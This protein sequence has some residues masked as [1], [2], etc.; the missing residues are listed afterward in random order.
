MNSN[1]YKKNSPRIIHIKN[2]ESPNRLKIGGTMI[3]GP[4]FDIKKYL[5][6]INSGQNDIKK[7]NNNLQILDNFYKRTKNDNRKYELSTIGNDNLSSYRRNQLR[8]KSPSVDRSTTISHN[9]NSITI[10]KNKNSINTINTINDDDNFKLRKISI[11]KAYANT[12]TN[13]GSLDLDLYNNKLKNNDEKYNFIKE[14]K[15]I[16]KFINLSRRDK[17]IKNLMANRIA[18]D[19][20]NLDVIFKPIKIINDYQNYKQSE[21]TKNKDEISS[22]L[23]ESKEISKKNLIIKLLNEKKNDYNK[24]IE[25]RQKTIENN[26]MTLDIFENDFNTYQTSQKNSYRKL[27]E[28][29][30]QLILKNR[31]LLKEISNLKSEVRI[32]ED[33]RQKFLERIDELRIIAKFVTKVLENNLDIFQIKIIPDYSSERLP[34]YE[35]ISKEVFERFHF[36]L[37][38]EGKAIISQEDINIIKQINH[39]N[40]AELL[41]SQFHKIEEDII[42]ILN[43]KEAILKEIS[44]MKKEE[45]RQTRDIQ[46]RIEDLE[47]ELNSYKSIY[48]REK[49]VYD[50][51][52]KRNYTGEGEFHD[53]IKD[54]YYEVMEVDKN[55]KKTKKSIVNI[56]RA[57][58]DVKKSII[59]KEININKLIMTL[60]QY[61][62]EDNYLFVRVVHNRKN[63]NKEMKINIQKKKIEEGERAKLFQLSM[64]HEKIILI[65][66]KCEPPF[67]P[68]KKEKIVKI[69]PEIVKEMENDELI[70][71]K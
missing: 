41:Y 31:S 14:I 27:D 39:L 5:N 63:E 16:K 56:N 71:Y 3:L 9:N 57:A 61:E 36:L 13:S 47:N 25:E 6:N 19:P 35:L 58:L 42:N 7:E 68:K 45:K 17:S 69:D 34:N 51:V 50:E 12:E 30:I 54:L 23:T 24:E 62:K 59:E 1:S 8:I 21:L 32:K 40:D 67:R 10:N 26:K 22:F 29:L 15:S 18:Y 2:Y 53:I 48:E 66:R 46:K 37:N 60:E 52:Y 43:N 28:I 20:K 65:Q 38:E 49:N 33:E 55:D 44:E 11:R 70:T 64:P 4:K